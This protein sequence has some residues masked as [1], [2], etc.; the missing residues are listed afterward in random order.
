MAVLTRPR[1]RRLPAL[2]ALVSLAVS[3]GVLAQATRDNDIKAAYLYNFTKFVEWPASA[4]PAEDF[5][6]CVVG[7]PDLARALDT[8]IAGE[9]VNG[10]R[11]RR[12][13]P[14]TSDQVRAC[15][16]LYVGLRQPGLGARLL[17]VVRDR[18]VLT[19]G[20]SDRFAA[21]GGAI[22]FVRE[23]DKVRFDVSKDALN[24]AGL[25]PSSKLLRVARRVRGGP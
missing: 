14:S 9:S 7:D 15:Q 19:V 17:R 16:I 25:R 12:I 23:N 1:T 11:L 22:R 10:R 4:S 20:N 18:P 5:N 13:S 3:A 8:I 6:L 2:V 24:R 21:D